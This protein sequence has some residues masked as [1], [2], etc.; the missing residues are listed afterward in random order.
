MKKRKQIALN[1]IFNL[2]MLLG[3]FFAFGAAD[4]LIEGDRSWGL[5]FGIVSL[6]LIVLSAIATPYCYV[7]DDEGVS[8]RYLFFSAERYLW[9]DV[10][11]I[12]V[13]C[14]TS[15]S[16]SVL[17][18]LFFSYDFCI[19]GTNV[20]SQLFFM[21]GHIRKSLCTKRLLEKYWDGTITGYLFEDVKEKKQK[22]RAQKN[23]RIKAH[24]TNEIVPMEREARANARE[25]LE[26]FVA[27]ARLYDLEI[28][29]RYL[30]ITKDLEELPSRPETGYTYTLLAEI[31][32]FGETD[33]DRIV[34]VSVD[35]L[36][37]RLGK[38][39][40]R[41]VQN[42][43][44]KEELDGLFSEMLEEIGKTGIEAYCKEP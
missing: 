28:K 30:Y 5:A 35:L 31:A 37:V 21:K 25:W 23:A 40:Y 14:T 34:V 44:A 6:L 8:L 13:V 7:F 33:E 3:A 17:F 16:H 41:G 43:H 9:R 15:S 1:K 19:H 20:G 42:T 18:E 12:E 36:F 39:A 24:L 32:R 26:P 10:H 4:L 29:T 38:T 22:K 27:Q 2:C 11:S